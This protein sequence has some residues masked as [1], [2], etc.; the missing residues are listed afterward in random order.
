MADYSPKLV[1]S[2]NILSRDRYHWAVVL[3]DGH[4]FDARAGGLSIEAAAASMAI[5]GVKALAA[6]NRV[7][8]E[9]QPAAQAGEVGNG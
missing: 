3:P 8:D 4:I 7:W 2:R 5:E 6:A 1:L 9:M